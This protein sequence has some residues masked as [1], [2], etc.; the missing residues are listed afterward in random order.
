MPIG[1]SGSFLL[2]SF[3]DNHDD[4]MAMPVE[5]ITY[6][7]FVA[8]DIEKSIDNF[9]NS[10]CSLWFFPQ[11]FMAHDSLI[12]NHDVQ[13]DS[14]VV[15]REALR[16]TLLDLCKLSPPLSRKDF[17]ILANIAYYHVRGKNISSIKYLLVNLHKAPLREVRALRQDFPDTVALITARD[18]RESVYSLCVYFE[19][20]LGGKAPFY[21]A[22][23]KIFHLFYLHSRVLKT[24]AGLSA[25]KIQIIDLNRLHA[26]GDRALSE[27]ADYLGISDTPALHESTFNGA[28]WAGNAGSGEKKSGLSP[29][30]AK[31]KYPAKMADDILHIVD[32]AFLPTYKKLHYPLPEKT[33]S[34][35]QAARLLLKYT[36]SKFCLPPFPRTVLAAIRDRS[37]NPQENA[38][39]A[40]LPCRIAAE[41]SIYLLKLYL[42]MPLLPAALGLI[43]LIKPLQSA[44]LH[45]IDSLPPFEK[46]TLPCF[47]Q[48]SPDV[49]DD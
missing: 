24:I 32:T 25:P 30:H 16:D 35:P 37:R 42:I 17:F 21:F 14:Y 34:P 26:T 18:P 40:L 41:Q 43:F 19:R 38:S 23:T 31:Y 8:G 11:S 15:D 46:T 48:K 13:P 45:S 4:V 27:L 49:A 28:F 7:L 44:L 10:Y 3:F 33:L 20:E 9:I 29:V 6:D 12:L 2:H 22:V 5:H 36:F 47:A 39:A 1:R